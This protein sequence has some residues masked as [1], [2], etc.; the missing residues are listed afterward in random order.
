MPAT[1]THAGI[2]NAVSAHPE[3]TRRKAVSLAIREAKNTTY[4]VQALGGAQLTLAQ[5]AAQFD[6]HWSLIRKASGNTT[7]P[8]RADFNESGEGPYANE[9]SRKIV[10][11]C[12]AI[13]DKA[14]VK[15]GT[16]LITT[17][18]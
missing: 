11:E 7:R 1:L 6:A 16:A 10:A 14:G 2:A 4:A 5:V 3:V 17:A 8:E 12:K 18:K 13:L 15:K 9:Y